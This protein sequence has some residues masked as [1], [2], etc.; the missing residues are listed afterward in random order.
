[1]RCDTRLDGRCTMKPG[2]D[3]K[4][5]VKPIVYPL[6]QAVTAEPTARRATSW[7][8]RR[9][10]QTVYRSRWRHGRRNGLYGACGERRAR[11]KW[12][13]LFWHPLQCLL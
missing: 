3:L 12:N 8:R 4:L 11:S 9:V 13:H 2:N 7:G 1:L 6:L 5:P 10:Q